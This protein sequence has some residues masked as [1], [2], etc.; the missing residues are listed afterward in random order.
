MIG[1][2]ERNV[3]T[4]ARRMVELHVVDE[5]DRIDEVRGLQE[6]PRPI[7][8]PELLAAEEGDVVAIGSVVETLSVGERTSVEALVA[9][10]RQA[11]EKVARQSADDA[12]PAAG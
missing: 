1:S 8:R 11:L 10:D 12:E 2:L 3:L 7:T 9:A 4:S 6:V 5:K